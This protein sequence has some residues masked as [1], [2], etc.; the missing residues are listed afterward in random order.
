ML[1]GDAAHTTHFTIGSGTK[2][3]LEDAIGLAGETDSPRDSVAL[4][5]LPAPPGNGNAEEIE[6]E[7]ASLVPFRQE[8]AS[9]WSMKD[10]QLIRTRGGRRAH[11]SELG[12]VVLI[13]NG[14][15]IYLA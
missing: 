12:S 7:I 2:L 13:T 1:V 4:S 15:V 5:L 11:N 3:A 9:C 14:G 6:E 10:V 8:R